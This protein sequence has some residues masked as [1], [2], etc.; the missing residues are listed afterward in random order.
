MVTEFAHHIT[1]NPLVFGLDGAIAFAIGLLIISY[2]TV[3]TARLN[4]VDSLK[5][6]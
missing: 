3:K 2:H 4:P 5:N 6:E 1:I